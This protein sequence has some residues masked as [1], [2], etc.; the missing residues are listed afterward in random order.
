[1][2]NNPFQT[3]SQHHWTPNR[4]SQQ[5]YIY[6][7]LLSHYYPITIPLLSHYYPITIPLLSHCYL[8]GGLTILKDM[9]SSMGKMTSHI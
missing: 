8:V 3:P 7:P 2:N 9:S 5:I 6:I 1:M 4:C